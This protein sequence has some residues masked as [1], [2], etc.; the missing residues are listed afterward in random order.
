MSKIKCPQCKDRD[1]SV[2]LY[3]PPDK[4]VASCC[5][6]G[7]TALAEDFPEQSLFDLITQSPE[8][9][10]PRLVFCAEYKTIRPMYLEGKGGIIVGEV[11]KSTVIAGAS[12]KT[13]SEA[14]AATLARLE[15]ITHG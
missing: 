5:K 4:D 14:I 10:A 11:W 15:E 9:L 8:V 3:T 2:T 1:V 13:E 12:F 7:Y 6:C